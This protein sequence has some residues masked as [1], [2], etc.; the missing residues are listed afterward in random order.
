MGVD[1]DLPQGS[2]TVVKG[3]TYL[4]WHEVSEGCEMDQKRVSTKCSCMADYYGEG[5]GCKAKM[6][7]E[8][9]EVFP[10]FGPDHKR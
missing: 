4:E 1:R 2:L 8:L 10:G 6:K 7:N 3:S 9:R 5:V